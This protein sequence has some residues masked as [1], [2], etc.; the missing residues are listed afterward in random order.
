MSDGRLLIVDDEPAFGA[1]VR[2]VAERMGYEV[3]VTTQA[4]EFQKA[5]DGFAPTDIV[6]DIVM[7]DADGI[8]LIRW[9]A[10]KGS[11]AR[12]IIASGSNPDYAKAA[13]VLGAAHGLRS[14]STLRKPVS[15]ADLRA[16]LA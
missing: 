15:L 5:F 13:E 12:I 1:F 9:I 3:Q 14:I 16:A 6:I 10:D 8:E 11:N 7:P 4:R 2:T